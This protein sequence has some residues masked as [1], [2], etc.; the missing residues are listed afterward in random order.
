MKPRSGSR[1]GAGGS[2]GV[3]ERAEQTEQTEP[4]GQEEKAGRGTL[5]IDEIA[6][7]FSTE[8]LLEFLEADQRPVEADPEFRERLREE[9]WALVRKQVERKG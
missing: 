3:A 9:L 2:Q 7:E 8:E 5:V 6:A 4:T 1:Q